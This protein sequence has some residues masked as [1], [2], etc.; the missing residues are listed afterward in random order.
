M[1]WAKCGDITTRVHK[2]E[3]EIPL[4]VREDEECDLKVIYEIFSQQGYKNQTKAGRCFERRSGDIVLDF[5]A[6]LG[7]AAK[8]F[9]EPR[10]VA[11]SR[12]DCYEPGSTYSLLQ[13]NFQNDSRATLHQ[14]A[15]M[16]GE[17]SAVVPSIKYIIGV[18]AEF[19]PSL[20]AHAPGK[21][22]DSKLN[23]I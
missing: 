2:K 12:V 4:A 14:C 22:P 23:L 15:V 13:R 9:L 6:H 3:V 16:F 11:V 17:M 18:I 10:P 21:L 7:A 5:G 20:T 19:W 1:T 8:W